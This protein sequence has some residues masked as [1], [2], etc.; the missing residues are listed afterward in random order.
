MLQTSIEY[1]TCQII[2]IDVQHQTHGKESRSAYKKCSTP[3]K[4]FILQ[5]GRTADVIRL[6]RSGDSSAYH[7]EQTMEIKGKLSPENYNYKAQ[8]S[9]QRDQFV[10]RTGM[11]MAR[12]AVAT[13]ALNIR[14]QLLLYKTF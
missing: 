10:F 14:I 13:S 2:V 12:V 4:L 9:L 11:N 5:L 7:W 6:P 1:K 8:D 3:T